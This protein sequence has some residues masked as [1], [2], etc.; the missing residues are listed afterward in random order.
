MLKTFSHIIL[1]LILLVSTM[2]MTVSKHYCQGNLYSVSVD[3]LNNDKC[4]MGSCCHDETQV[5][6]VKEDFSI[7][8]ISTVPM[9]AELDILGHDL[10]AWEGIIAPEAE[11]TTPTERESPPL[12]PIQKTLAVKQ[13]YLL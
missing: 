9:L 1:S 2:G 12:L 3:G 4:D 11:N 7:P 13:V 5:Y 10:F 8:A 6:Q